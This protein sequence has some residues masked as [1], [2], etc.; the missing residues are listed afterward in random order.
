MFGATLAAQ[1]GTATLVPP[2]PSGLVPGL[3]FVQAWRP[4]G[5]GMTKIVGTV[6]DIRQVP[7]KNVSVRL[8]DI[9]TGQ[10]VAVS[11]TNDNGEYEF[12]DIEPGTYV[13]EMFIG[14]R[15][16]VALSNAGAIARNETLQ[17]VI[18]LPGRW[19]A[20]AQ[21]VV[22]IRNFGSFVGMSSADTLSAATLTVAGSQNIPAADPGEPVSPR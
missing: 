19:D 22:P 2:P 17:T 11:I 15:Y 5:S 3:K 6:I 14:D 9:V 20:A 10:V 16:V 12:P 7:V 18:I 13:V 4:D 1:R 21:K 8:R